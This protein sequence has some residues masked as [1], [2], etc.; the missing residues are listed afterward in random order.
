MQFATMFR[1][2]V[3]TVGRQLSLIF[4]NILKGYRYLISPWLANRCRFHPSCSEYAIQAI[5]LYGVVKGFYLMTWRLL[6]CQPW[7]PG[8]YDPVVVGKKFNLEVSAARNSTLRD[9]GF[10]RERTA[11]LLLEYEHRLCRAEHKNK[12]VIPNGIAEV[13]HEF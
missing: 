11:I 10:S 3:Q 6:R 4:V 13:N 9:G 7:H 2:T 12:K 1:R 5:Q 8:G